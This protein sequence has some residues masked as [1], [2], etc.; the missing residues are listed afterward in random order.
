MPPAVKHKSGI[1]IKGLKK[2]QA[3]PIVR[4]D[5]VNPTIKE[6]INAA[7]LAT[8][9]SKTPTNGMNFRRA[10]IGEKRQKNPKIVNR[11]PTV[12]ITLLENSRNSFCCSKN[13]SGSS[14]PSTKWLITSSNGPILIKQFTAA[15]I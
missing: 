9:A 10:M 11:I 8:D 2:T 6:N 4:D 7:K 13:F 12:R 1:P 14:I 5:R 15:Q 3:T